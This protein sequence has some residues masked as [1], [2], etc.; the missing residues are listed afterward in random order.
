MTVRSLICIPLTSRLPTTS[1]LFYPLKPLSRSYRK[2]FQSF[3]ESF[4]DREVKERTPTRNFFLLDCVIKQQFQVLSRLLYFTQ[5]KKVKKKEKQVK[6]VYTIHY[7]LA[8]KRKKGFCREFFVASQ[9]K[10]S[11][12]QNCSTVEIN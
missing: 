10:L 1:L 11:K 5:R 8:F 7:P 9:Y 2:I 12:R 6:K 3:Y 4:I